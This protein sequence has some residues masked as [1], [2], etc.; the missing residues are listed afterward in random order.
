MKGVVAVKFFP[1]G[2]KKE[3]TVMV[4]KMKNNDSKL[5]K[6]ISEEVIIPQLHAFI[7][8]DT[9]AEVMIPT[10]QIPRRRFLNDLSMK[11]QNPD[12]VN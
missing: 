7:K 9:F 11:L 3:R 12:D 5:V 6:L 4:N 2:K 8:H 10:L 1:G